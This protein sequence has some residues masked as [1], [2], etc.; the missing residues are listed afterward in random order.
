MKNVSRAPT[1]PS[2]KANGARWRRELLQ[3]L[4]R[5]ERSGDRPRRALIDRYRQSDVLEA[6]FD[7]Y[8]GCCCYCEGPVGEQSYSRIEHRRPKSK[9]PEE[10]FEWN[11]LHLV[12]EICNT[13]KLDKWNPDHPILDAV[14][15]KPIGDH[16]TYRES[17]ILG[18]LRE[19]LSERGCTTIEHA[20]LNRKNSDGLPGTRAGILLEAQTT[21]REILRKKRE[22]TA[23]QRVRQLERELRALAEGGTFGSVILWAID[24][25]LG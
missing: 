4:D 17:R 7:M 8:N 2:L 13:K 22:G 18:L 10:T 14:E 9:F 25:Y 20:D 3:E 23:P 15:D 16:L 1:P 12:C 5:C 6:L 11:N 21:I 24:E 19:G